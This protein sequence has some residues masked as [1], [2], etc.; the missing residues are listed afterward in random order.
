MSRFEGVGELRLKESDRLDAIA[1]GLTALGV[2][3][4][5]GKDWFEVHGTAGA[6]FMAAELD[7]LGDHRLAMAWA[8]AGLRA[9]GPVTI[10]AFDACSVSYPD[11]ADDLAALRAGS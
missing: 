5:D 6:P 11:F 9:D 2:T 10:D 7:S 1:D 3:V 8:V 4:R